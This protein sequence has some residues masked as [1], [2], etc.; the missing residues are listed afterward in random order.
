MGL[1]GWL[2]LGGVL[3]IL[4]LVALFMFRTPISGLLNRIRSIDRRGVRIDPA[5]QDGALVEK[6]P[7][8]EAE[9]LLRELEG[10]LIRE[11]EDHVT[12]EFQTRG[13]AGDAGLRVAIRYTS[14][15][16]I[17]LEFERLYRLIW[18]SQ[19]S[20]LSHLNT[21]R[22]GHTRE[23]LRAFYTLAATQYPETYDS[24]SYDQWLAFLLGSILIR[25]DHGRI[26]ITVRGC[27]FITH[28]AKVG[29]TLNKPG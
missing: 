19:L 15:L 8:T 3:L 6:D 14:A 16:S 5:Q 12:K 11:I 28:L 18:G 27:E 13:L 17:A 26:Q 7:R 24:I 21:D 29:Y 10:P 2:T 9:N 25:E 23:A 1:E 4:G 22:Q 20:L